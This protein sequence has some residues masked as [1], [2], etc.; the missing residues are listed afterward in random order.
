VEAE[1]RAE[2]SDEI[3][4]S[5]PLGAVPAQ[6]FVVVRVVGGQDAVEPLEEHGVVCRNAQPLFVHAF[7]ERLRAVA[8]GIPQLGMQAGEHRASRAIPAVPEIVCE[9]LQALQPLGDLRID[10]EQ[11]GSAACHDRI[12]HW[13]TRTIVSLARCCETPE[14][15]DDSRPERGREIGARCYKT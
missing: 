4:L 11:E 15:R 5:Q 3:V 6:G 12:I 14:L 7:Q 1:L 10:F 9:F 8:H 13:E 2:V